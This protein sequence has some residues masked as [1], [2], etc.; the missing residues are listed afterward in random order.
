MASA[1]FE[2]SLLCPVGALVKPR[3]RAID[4]CAFA[5]DGKT[6]A[7]A[8]PPSRLAAAAAPR[9]VAGCRRASCRTTWTSSSTTRRSAA[10]RAPAARAA[11][12]SAT[13]AGLYDL[14]LPFTTT[15]LPL[16]SYLYIG[17]VP[18]L[19][20]YPFWRLIGD[21]VAV[22]VQGAVFVLVWLAAR[23]AAAAR[24]PR[25]AARRR[26]SSR[27]LLVTFVVDEGP[28]GLSAVVFLGAL[29][30]LRRALR[31]RRRA[32][33][34]RRAGARSPASCSS[35]AVGE[36]RVRLVAAGGRVLRRVG[37]VA[38]AAR[39]RRGRGAS[40]R[41]ALAAAALACACRPRCCSRASTA[42]A[43]STS[44]RPSTAGGSSCGAR[45]RQDEAGRLWTYAVDG[46]RVAPR[47]LVLPPWPIG[48]VPGPRPPGARRGRRCADRG[49][50]RWRPGRLSAA[51]TFAFVSS[52]AYSQWPHHF[53]FPLLLLVLGL[54]S[55]LDALSRRGRAAVAVA[56]SSSGRRSPRAGRG[57]RSRPTR[58]SPRT[59]C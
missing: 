55:A 8:L 29:V 21:P 56:S 13:A 26:S 40:S 39:S 38:A 43:G 25:V 4:G 24:G 59:S 1:R 3:A 20:F 14:R 9:G 52:S 49:G 10:R 37:R 16:R 44:T 33:R 23:G 27:V 5:P 34:A 58:P 30:A 2:R 28:V 15:P 6:D 41:P 45:E 50:A 54:A 53:F 57:P 32:S 19:P 18:A 35:R 36:A 17:S 47:N 48:A 22:R 31:G 46:A 12:L 51:V 11:E 7:R 42:T